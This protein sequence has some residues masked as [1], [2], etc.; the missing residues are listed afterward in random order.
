MLGQPD[1]A[2]FEVKTRDGRILTTSVTGPPQ[3][4]PVFLLH[5]TPG[6]RTGPRPRASV[7]YRRGIRLISYDRPG[8]GG[9]TRCPDRRVADVAA[10]VADIAADL[11]ITK[12][13]SVVGRSGGGSAALACAALLPDRIYRAA[14]LVGLAPNNPELS[15]TSGMT[16]QNGA[17]YA[18]AA[19]ADPTA[20][21]ERLLL[22]SLRM[23]V[24]P[25]S[26]LENLLPQLTAADRLVL[27]DA[28]LRRLLVDAYEEAVRSGP[29]GWIDDV[30]AASRD[31][32]FSFATISVPVRIWH[33]VDDN[34]S[35]VAHARWLA[36]HV[37]GALLDLQ[38]DSAHFG[39]LEVLPD[40]LTWLADGAPDQASSEG[41]WID[42]PLHEPVPAHR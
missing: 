18:K 41:Q 31:W 21:T 16:E 1:D 30:L 12:R 23:A 13:F 19:E 11:G 17:D 42:D 29:F 34:F 28:T 24:D 20:I 33:G 35:P 14:T 27:N 3:G 37:P 8:Y 22:R 2:S 39:A 36:R 38:P 6:S 10:D 15:F 9:S 25:R 7:L 32:G 4:W 5:G 40:M 26:L